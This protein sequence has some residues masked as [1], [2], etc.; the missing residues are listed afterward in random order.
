VREQGVEM[1]VEGGGQAPQDVFE[2]GA[3]VM[4]LRLGAFNQGVADAGGVAAGLAAG[5]QPV[6]AVMRSCA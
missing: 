4:A 1:F 3:R 5:E 6:F 2:V